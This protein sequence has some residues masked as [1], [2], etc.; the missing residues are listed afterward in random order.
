MA[1]TM[2]AY[3]ELKLLHAHIAFGTGTIEQH[4]LTDDFCVISPGLATAMLQ[5]GW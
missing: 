5:S 4:Y 2:A 3:V 1:R